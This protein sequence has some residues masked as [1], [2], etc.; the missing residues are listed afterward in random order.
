MFLLATDLDHAMSQ[1]A[2]GTSNSNNL[3]IHHVSSSLDEVLASVQG[4]NTTTKVPLLLLFLL[5]SS[6]GLYLMIHLSG[7]VAVHKTFNTERKSRHVTVCMLG[8]NNDGRLKWAW[9]VSSF[10][11]YR[12]S[13]PI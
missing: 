8:G 12:W 4:Y 5:F 6:S 2:E 10:Q 1:L 3:K 13:S 7:Y 11:P 9:Q